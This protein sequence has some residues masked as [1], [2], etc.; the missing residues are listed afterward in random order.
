[1]SPPL[2]PTIR[3]PTRTIWHNTRIIDTT[4]QTIDHLRIV[5]IIQNYKLISRDLINILNTF[6]WA[7]KI[8]KKILKIGLTEIN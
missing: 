2:L 7:W 3:L 8:M 1:M 6:F 5:R 4:D